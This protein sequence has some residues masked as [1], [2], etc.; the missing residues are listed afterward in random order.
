MI[1]FLIMIQIV[2]IAERGGKVQKIEVQYFGSV[3]AAAKKSKDEV[4]FVPNMTVYGLLRQLACDYANDAENFQG[5]IFG[6]NGR[7]LRED[8]TVTVNGTIINHASASD[9][10]LEAGDVLALFP[11]FPGGG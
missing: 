4:E 7:E 2:N 11:I 3:R 8:L 10:K 9:I 1:I 5:E 6:E